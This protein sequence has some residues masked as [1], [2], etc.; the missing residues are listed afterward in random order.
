MFH[1][2][3]ACLK[4]SVYNFFFFVV[5]QGT[6]TNDE[7][8]DLG[9]EIAEKWTKLGRRLDVKEP[10]L[11]E[12]CRLYDLLSEKGFHMLL[13]WRQEQGSAATYQALCDGL[14][15]KL[16][17]RQ[18]LAEQF[19]YFDGNCVLCNIKWGGAVTNG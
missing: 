6:P 1:R 3:F 19:C 8:E 18:D 5:K 9:A 7:L 2:V 13:Q 10:K 12:I 17:Q 15:H 14:R 11:Q 4:Q 16:V